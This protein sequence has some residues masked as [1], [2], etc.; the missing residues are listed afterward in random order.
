MI[1]VY[2]VPLPAAR[3]DTAAR[4]VYHLLRRSGTQQFFV[5]IALENE[6][7]I[8]LPGRGQVMADTQANHVGSSAR[9]EIQVRTFLYK[10][11]SGYATSGIEYLP[12]ARLGPKAIIFFIEKAGPGIEQLVSAGSF[13]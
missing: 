9:H 12:M 10:K 5:H 1:E 2:D 13:L 11:D 4:G 8:G 6:V 7:R 3:C